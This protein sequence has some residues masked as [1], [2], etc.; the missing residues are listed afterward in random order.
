MG[1]NNR[2]VNKRLLF[3]SLL[4]CAFYN[5]QI[6][7]DNNHPLFRKKVLIIDDNE[8]EQYIIASLLVNTGAIL[9]PAYTGTDGIIV[10]KAIFPDLIIL[11]KILPDLSPLKVIE[12]IKLISDSP[13][14][15]YTVQL[16]NEDWPLLQKAGA[17]ELLIKHLPVDKLIGKLQQYIL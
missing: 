11:D 5:L 1:A 16:L 2:V 12:G 6:M 10:A 9:Y 17:V 8:M 4:Y 7:M 3:K 15:L 13:I 14:I